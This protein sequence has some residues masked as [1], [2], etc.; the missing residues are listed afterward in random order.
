MLIMG[1]YLLPA[2]LGNHILGL[3]SNRFSTRISHS[4]ISFLHLAYSSQTTTNVLSL[5]AFSPALDTLAP[6]LGHL[7][8]CTLSSSREHLSLTCGALP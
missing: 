6:P 1:S 5:F 3:S 2:G 7:Y 4:N 8:Y